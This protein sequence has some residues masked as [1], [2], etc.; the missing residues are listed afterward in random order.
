MHIALRCRQVAAVYNFA[1]PFSGLAASS[2][3]RQKRSRHDT[4]YTVYFEKSASY[5]PSARLFQARPTA[6]TMIIAART[7]GAGD[8]I[9]HITMST[10]AVASTID[11]YDTLQHEL[12]S[13]SPS[14]RLASSLYDAQLCCILAERRLTLISR[15][16]TTRHYADA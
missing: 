6:S 11:D 13:I 10:H 15:C 16:A 9:R 5:S 7:H 8:A 4:P 12:T 2:C 14:R 1:Q 3:L